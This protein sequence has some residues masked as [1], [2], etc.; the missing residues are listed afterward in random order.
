MKRQANFELLRII[1]MFGVVMNHVFTY[2][3]DTYDSFSMDTSSVGGFTLWSILEL[4]TLMVLPSVNCYILLTGYFL[5]DRT[6]LRAK[7]ICR[8]WFITWIYAVGIYLLAV[9]VGIEPFRWNALWLH[10]TPLYSN[11]YWFVTSYLTLMLLAPLLSWL[12]QHASK[13]Q[14]QVALAVGAIVCFQLFLGQ[15]VMDKQQILLFI[16]LFMIGGYIRRYCDIPFNRALAP[17]ASLAML[18]VMYAYTLYKNQ[19]SGNPFHVY[20]MEYHGLVLPF[21]VAI[22]LMVKNWSIRSTTAC[23]YILAIA[24]LSFAVY[25]IHHHP[26]VH[27]LLW[28]SVGKMLLSTSVYWLPLLCVAVALVV[29]LAGIAIEWLRKSLLNIYPYIKTQKP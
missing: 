20:A 1:A 15:Y 8:V 28:D 16:Y 25:V 10:A 7:G 14:Y 18:M 11:T 12:L 3:L 22:F 29:F 19:Q 13:L 27:R 6:Q 4:M 26:I 23:R 17:V 24:P 2:G 21:S 5:I 9:V